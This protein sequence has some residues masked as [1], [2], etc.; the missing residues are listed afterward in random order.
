MITVIQVVHVAKGKLYH[1]ASAWHEKYIYCKYILRKCK[2]KQCV[3]ILP[4]KKAANKNEMHSQYMTSNQF[5]PSRYL[6]ICGDEGI[7]L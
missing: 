4:R 1:L 7:E 2:L 3:D 5:I 6:Y